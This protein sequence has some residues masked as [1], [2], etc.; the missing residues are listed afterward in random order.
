[1]ELLA[2]GG[3]GGGGGAGFAGEGRGVQGV[4]TPIT[5][6]VWDVEWVEARFG[7]L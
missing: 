7:G 4:P 2:P 3:L 1:M 6:A 5:G